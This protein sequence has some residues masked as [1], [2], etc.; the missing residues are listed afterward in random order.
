M[1]E[2]AKHKCKKQQGTI[3]GGLAVSNCNCNNTSGPTRLKLFVVIKSEECHVEATEAAASAMCLE[4]SRQISGR[5]REWQWRSLSMQKHSHHCVYLRHAVFSRPDSVIATA[6][7]IVCK[8]S[9]R[10]CHRLATKPPDIANNR[11]STCVPTRIEA[12]AMA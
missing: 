4:M 1:L 2:A 12:L 6:A 9:P 11:S 10:G 5:N 8:C 3:S 7:C